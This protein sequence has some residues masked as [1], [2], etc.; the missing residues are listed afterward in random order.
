MVKKI[1]VN[2]GKPYNSFGTHLND[3]VWEIM[4]R[5]EVVCTCNKKIEKKLSDSNA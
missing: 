1:C 5:N 4:L 3:I 2:C